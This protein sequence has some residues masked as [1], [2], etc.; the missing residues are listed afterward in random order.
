MT[1]R[2]RASLHPNNNEILEFWAW[3]VSVEKDLSHFTNESLHDAL[4]ARLR[5]L[6]KIAWELG[7]GSTAENAFAISPDGNPD[8][9]PLTKRIVALAPDVPGWEF[10]PARPP[11]AEWPEFSIR[12]ADGC[13]IKV[14][15]QSWR[16]VLY[17]F[18]DRDFDIVI[19]QNDLAASEETRYT[20]AVVLLD[21][22]LGEGTRLLCI[23][24]VD[25]VATLSPEQENNASP[26]AVLPK[27]LDSLCGQR[28]GRVRLPS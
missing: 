16:Y 26:I 23:K 13:K 8:L 7:P 28:S 20:A 19:E 12:G 6:G 24:A 27:H 14:N 5:R 9:L 3:F 15:A 21:A 1:G 17:S 10:H 25:P 4:D 2:R 22:L 18:G 11:R